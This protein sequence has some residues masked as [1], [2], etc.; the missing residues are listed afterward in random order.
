MLKYN[1]QLVNFT[2]NQDWIER[3]L[4]GGTTYFVYKLLAIIIVLGGILYM[5]GL[6][7]GLAQQILAPLGKALNPGQN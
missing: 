6:G 2:G 5:T 7:S 3:Y 4:G 1:Y